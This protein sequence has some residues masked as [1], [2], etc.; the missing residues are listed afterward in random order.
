MALPSV[1]VLPLLIVCAAG[2]YYIYNEVI[3]F[4][5][6]TLVRNKVVVISDAV[7]GVGTGIVQKCISFSSNTLSHKS[8]FYEVSSEIGDNMFM[9]HFQWLILAGAALL[10]SVSLYSVWY[11][12]WFH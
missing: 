10:H 6:K 1:M 12:L 8:R 3:Q 7:S 11:Q 2:V 5:S 9:H 4:M